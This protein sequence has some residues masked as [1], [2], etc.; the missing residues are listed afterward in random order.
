MIASN[1][2]KQVISL[3]YFI[4]KQGLISKLESE[5]SD[6]S[7]AEAE[8]FT[9]EEEEEKEEAPTGEDGDDADDL[10]SYQRYLGLF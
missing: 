6:V 10:V 3:L 1:T 8:A 4:E 7:K 9:K 2:I 5:D